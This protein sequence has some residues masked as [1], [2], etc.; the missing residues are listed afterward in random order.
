MSLK[1][2]IAASALCVG[3]M[4]TV[5][6]APALPIG[7]VSEAVASTGEQVQVVCCVGRPAARRAPGP[8]GVGRVRRR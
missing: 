5:S 8:R 7:N 6:A 4:L 2:L 3:T 1:Y